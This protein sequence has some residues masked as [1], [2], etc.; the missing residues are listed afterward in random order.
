MHVCIFIQEIL[1]IWIHVAQT[2]WLA[3]HINVWFS[4]VQS[5]SHVQLFATPRIAARQASL[6]ITNSQSLLKLMPIESVTPDSMIK[7]KCLACV[8]LKQKMPYK[9]KVLIATL[10]IFQRISW[11]SA[12]NIMAWFWKI[13]LLCLSYYFILAVFIRLPNSGYLFR[14]VTT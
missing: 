4:S 7:V 14:K 8:N 5:L 10:C 6:S 2:R 1:F 3:K 12:W 9:H 13:R 11:P